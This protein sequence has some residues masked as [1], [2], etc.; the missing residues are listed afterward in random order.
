MKIYR[1]RLDI[2]DE[3]V[4][5]SLYQAWETFNKRVREGFYGPAMAHIEEGLGTEDDP[6]DYPP[7]DDQW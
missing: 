2:D 6:R 4:A 5:D 3:L 1:L 7:R